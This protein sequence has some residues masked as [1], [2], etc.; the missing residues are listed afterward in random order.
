MSEIPEGFDP[1]QVILTTAGQIMEY[2]AEAWDVG[3]ATGWDDMENIDQPGYGV[4][5]PNP[6]VQHETIE[7]NQ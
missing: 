1:D 6:Y 5:S 4:T 3:F 2:A 7:V